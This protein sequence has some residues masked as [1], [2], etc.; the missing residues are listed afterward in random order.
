[1][2]SSLCYLSSY[3]VTDARVVTATTKLAQV[4]LSIL[5]VPFPFPPFPP[6]SS[7]HLPSLVMPQTGLFAVILRRKGSYFTETASRCGSLLSSPSGFVPSL[8]KFGFNTNFDEQIMILLASAHAKQGHYPECEEI[9]GRLLQ[10]P[11]SSS[12]PVNVR[13]LPPSFPLPPLL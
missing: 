12:S 11:S 4:L 1:M 2:L 7:S 8:S 5:F 6:F 13:P 3:P 9:V 10:I